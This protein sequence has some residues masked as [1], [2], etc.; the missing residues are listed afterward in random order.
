MNTKPRAAYVHIPFCTQI[1]H[2][3][4]FSKVFIKNQPVDD[5][6]RALLEEIRAYEPGPIDTLYI[7]GGTPSALSAAQLEFLLEGLA[8]I[9]DIS[10]VQ[11]WTLEA[12]PGDLSQDKIEVMANAGLNRISLGVQTF[13]DRELRQIGRMHQEK[14]IYE[15]I[16][17]L[18]A[19]GFH[20][21]SIDLIY[22]LPNQT[23][24][25]VKTN[26]QKAL[27]LDIPHMSLYSL[28]LENHTVF[29]NR[30][31][32]GQL[33]LPQEDLEVDMFHYIINS[34]KEAG[35]DHYEISNFCRP[36][37]ESR[38]NLMYWDNAEYY[39]LGAGASGY[40]NGVR[41]RN[42]GPIRHYLNAVEAGNARVYE[43][44]LSLKEQMEEEL[45]LGLRKRA[46]IS[47]Q[48][49]EQKFQRSFEEV[50]GAIVAQMLEEGLLIR[51][52]DRLRTSQK[53]LFLGDTVAER[54]ILE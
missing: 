35:Y 3:C 14:D 46:G 42:H 45:F 7:G 31:R 39:G 51:E 17:R 40:L 34:L 1:C 9:F 6:L 13:N 26:V 18:K 16:D 36:G 44:K 21:I 12:N 24:E 33:N 50:Y 29:M 43:E 32:R 22:A 2:Y 4:D 20:N 37:Y 47:I 41:Y 49:F 8:S 23:M 54:F 25:Q 5:Y 15:N 27:A 11:E 28:I 48:R 52:G 19:A 53:G 30:M 10:Q 38:H